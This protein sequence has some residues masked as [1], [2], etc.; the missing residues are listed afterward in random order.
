MQ[1]GSIMSARAIQDQKAIALETFVQH[2]VRGN[3][4]VPADA[5]QGN[6]TIEMRVDCVLD[7]AEEKPLGKPLAERSLE[8]LSQVLWKPRAIRDPVFA[9]C[10]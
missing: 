9:D 7:N 5:H 1:W 4:V 6:V 8:E 10:I 3:A 2:V